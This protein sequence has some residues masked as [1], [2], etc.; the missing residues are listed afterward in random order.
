MSAKQ[1][2]ILLKMADS[3]N[4]AK[5]EVDKGLAEYQELER[6]I[7]DL[8][9][10][11]GN[12]YELK[13]QIDLKCLNITSNVEDAINKVIDEFRVD[14]A[15]IKEIGFLENL[16]YSINIH[17]DKEEIDKVIKEAL[18]VFIELGLKSS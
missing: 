8:E 2:E 16:L 1:Y 6:L 17:S 14:P 4:G 11:L 3:V 9:E 10:G 5:I 18:R 7:T 13:H 12:K 15:N